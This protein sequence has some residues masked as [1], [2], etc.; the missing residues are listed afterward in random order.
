MMT[1]VAA[2]H[3]FNFT[4]LFDAGGSVVQ[5]PRLNGMF[6]SW[7]T[8]QHIYPATLLDYDS[9]SPVAACRDDMDASSMQRTAVGK[10]PVAA[11]WYRQHGI[12]NA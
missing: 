3:A 1:V 2:K 7:N 12:I 11:V 8:H 9:P 5:E 4:N 6:L 10:V